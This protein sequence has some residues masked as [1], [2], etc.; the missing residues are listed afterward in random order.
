MKTFHA[1]KIP[2]LV[3]GLIAALLLTGCASTKVSDQQELVTGQLPR[4]GTIWVYDFVA[5]PSDVPPDSVLAGESD[6]DDTPQ[7]SEQIA[8]G[9]KLGAEIGA[10]LVKEIQAMGMPAM[11]AWPSTTPT[12]NDIVLRGY[13]LSIKEG[14]AAKRIVIGFGA[15]GSDLKTLVDGYQM[16]A[17]GLRKLGS[18]TVNASGNK[19]PGAALGVATFL[20]TKNP[21]GLIISSSMKVYGQASGKDTIEGRATS[22]AKEIGDVLKKRFQEQ[23]WIMAD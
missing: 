2:T 5:T 18:G 9:R 1:P 11:H 22:T 15:G 13:L 16:T 14:S 10:D 23:G 7:T 4:P 12:V 20:V 3:S 21:A 6:L 8:E 19:T 17:T